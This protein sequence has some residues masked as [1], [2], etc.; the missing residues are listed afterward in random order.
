VGDIT[1]SN[2]YSYGIV[3]HSDREEDKITRLSGN[4]RNS[5]AQRDKKASRLKERLV[6]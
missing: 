4:H 6:D 3:I 1:E 5:M 2:I